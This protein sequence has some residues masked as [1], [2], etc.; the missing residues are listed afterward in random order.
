[1][2][3]LVC[4]VLTLCMV[5]GLAAAAYAEPV[6]KEQLK[7]GY[8]MVGDENEGYTQSHLNGLKEAQTKL[9]LTDDQIIVKYN[10]GEG[11]T[12]YEAAADLADSGCQLIFSNSYGHESYMLQ[13]AKEYPNVQFCAATGDQAVKSGLSNAHN[14]FTFI[15]QARYLS[16]VVAGLKLNQL[17]ENGTITADTAKIGY[18]GAKPYAEIISGFT[19]FFLGARSVCPSATMTVKYTG[20]W[21][22]MA[23]EKECAEA[24]IAD[25]CV[26]I[27]QHADTTG[28]ASAC[29]PAG[30][31]IVGY[32]VSMTSVAPTMALVSPTNNWETYIEYAMNC[33]L[34][35]ETIAPDWCEG[36]ETD[37]VRLTE[38]NETAVAPGTAETV[39]EIKAKLID[40]SLQVYDCSTFTVGG[41]ELTTCTDVYGF[42]GNELVSDG[43]Y[44]EG[45]LRSA[46]CFSM[47]IDGIT[48]EQ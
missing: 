32:N 22:D 42:E 40:G 15:H 47:I 5:L 30:I 36:L 27:S 33:I 11:E 17:I 18:V 13:A 9:G 25:K 8:I 20:E 4:L 39:E 19:S 34:N 12:C 46:P 2:K 10:I 26:L 6:A 14:N 3:K 24:L 45:E 41:A 48:V 35:G 38:L 21:A 7:V 29:E 23:L 16:G 37:T 43:Y 1:M 28:A 31:P 44:H